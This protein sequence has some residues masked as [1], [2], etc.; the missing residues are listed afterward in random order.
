[1]SIS[2]VASTVPIGPADSR[3]DVSATGARRLRFRLH[4]RR[5]ETWGV[6]WR[7]INIRDP[8]LHS[9]CNLTTHHTTAVTHHFARYY[10][11]P[12]SLNTDIH[13]YSH[14]SAYLSDITPRFSSTIRRTQS[15]PAVE[16][17]GSSAVRP[18]LSARDRLAVLRRLETFQFSS[19]LG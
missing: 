14:T 16:L 1:V 3:A 17:G 2:E 18:C 6:V 10:A 9:G 12:R 5:F 8:R 11:V 4:R 15:V 13:Y 7:K 19:L